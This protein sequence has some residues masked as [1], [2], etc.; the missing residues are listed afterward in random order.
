[1]QIEHKRNEIDDIDASIVRLLN[2][3]AELAREISILKMSAGLGIIDTGREQDVISRAAA[4]T[5]HQS[6]IEGVENI[7]R[8]ILRESRQIQAAMHAELAANGVRS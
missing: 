5:R 1:M 6:D 7:F 3:R 4:A 8:A 2:R